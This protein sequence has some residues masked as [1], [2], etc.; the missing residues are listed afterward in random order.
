MLC[1]G[2]GMLQERPKSIELEFDVCYQDYIELL[3][4]DYLFKNWDFVFARGVRF[5]L[6]AKFRI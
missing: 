4:R 6:R 5:Q 1:S 3:H 2:V